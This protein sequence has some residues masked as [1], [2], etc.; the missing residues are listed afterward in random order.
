MYVD[1][2]KRY[3]ELHSRD[4]KE[5][6]M[7]ESEEEKKKKRSQYLVLAGVSPVAFWSWLRARGDT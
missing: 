5:Y 7:T 6:F 3:N 4:Q 1:K 2:I